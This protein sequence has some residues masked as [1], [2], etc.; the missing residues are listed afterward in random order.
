MTKRITALFFAALAVFSGCQRE[1][2]LQETHPQRLAPV[3]L[4][5]Q[6]E[7]PDTKSQVSSAVENFTCAYL[8]AFWNDSGAACTD[9]EGR[10]VAIYTEEKSFD[11]LLP[12]GDRRI[13]V[14]ALVNPFSELKQTLDG[15]LEQGTT[16]T[17]LGSLTYFCTDPEAFANLENDG[18]P[19]SGMMNGLRLESQDDPLVFTLKR[20]FTRVE[21]RIHTSKFVESGWS[22]QA[23]RVTGAQ[24]NTEVPYFY[25]GSGAGFRQEDASKL[26]TLDWATPRDI[27]TINTVG[28]DNKS[29]AFST[30]YFLEN[31]QGDIG[32]ASSWHKVGIELASLVT[33]CS[34]LSIHVIASKGGY[35][36]RTFTYRLYPGQDPLMCGNFDLIR[37]RHRKVTLKLAAPTDGFQWTE[38]EQTLLLPGSCFTLPFETTLRYSANAA[39]NELYFS[40]KREGAAT[41]DVILESVLWQEGNAGRPFGRT[42]AD[43]RTDYPYY[44]T[45]TFRVRES[46]E[47]GPVDIVGHDRAMDIT[48]TA[49]VVVTVPV[50][51][52]LK[53]DIRGLDIGDGEVGAWSTWYKGI[54]FAELVDEDEILLNPFLGGPDPEETVRNLSSL[55]ELSLEFETDPAYA[56]ESVPVQ[57]YGFP[58][59]LGA[60]DDRLWY[61]ADLGAGNDAPAHRIPA[62]CN[63]YIRFTGE[64]AIPPQE[65]H[66]WFHFFKYVNYKFSFDASWRATSEH[67]DTEV[68]VTPKAWFLYPPDWFSFDPASWG[69]YESS[70]LNGQWTQAVPVTDIVGTDNR[71]FNIAASRTGMS[72]LSSYITYGVSYEHPDVT[73]GRNVGFE[74][75]TYLVS[76]HKKNPAASFPSGYGPHMEEVTTLYKQY[77]APS[78]TFMYG[79]GGGSWHGFEADYSQRLA[80]GWPPDQIRLHAGG[81]ARTSGNMLMGDSSLARWT[82]ANAMSTYWSSPTLTFREPADQ[83][84]PGGTQTFR[85]WTNLPDAD[86]LFTLS[87]NTH[88]QILSVDKAEKTVTVRCLPDTQPGT[89]CTLTGTGTKTSANDSHSFICAYTSYYEVT[90]Y[91]RVYY[92]AYFIFDLN[93]GREYTGHYAFSIRT[94]QAGSEAIPVLTY[95]GTSGLC[96]TPSGDIPVEDVVQFLKLRH[97]ISGK[98][99]TLTPEGA[100]GEGPYRYVRT[101]PEEYYIGPVGLDGG[102]SAEYYGR[103]LSWQCEDLKMLVPLSVTFQSPFR[104]R[105]R[106]EFREAPTPPLFI[107]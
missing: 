87:D 27:Q 68:R 92:P 21:L 13:D 88:F 6:E 9:A 99:V 24:S 15:Y 77:A 69:D 29:T 90:L 103:F 104:N 97:P 74:N 89:L 48:D 2:P 33:R 39:E 19:M 17:Q 7:M 8:F 70:L 25:T 55:Y 72:V 46:A 83:I 5:L 85:Y 57:V 64:G 95:D 50:Y 102:G 14:W 67:T 96:H 41:A 78:I 35:K 47:V 12:V 3:T 42:G 45:A 107:D 66:L 11:W 86:Y 26:A 44:G 81:I 100:D 1:V 56:S 43:R 59:V 16:R 62:K 63:V 79:S 40:C 37:N 52:G 106:I 93:Y 98:T 32:P 54:P 76:L 105:F 49:P 82:N 84:P 38:E 75:G 30:F 28:D 23:A 53:E 101:T 65:K 22:V 80:L 36:D 61:G 73:D 10:P 91:K 60:A 20:L 58:Q 34:Y 71:L 94:V 4:L 51:Q 31:C 18:M